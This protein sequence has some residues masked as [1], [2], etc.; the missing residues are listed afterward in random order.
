MVDRRVEQVAVVGDDDRGAR[1]ALQ[2]VVEPDRTLD[3]EV[4]GRL[5]EQQ[6]VGLGEQHRGE[7]HPHPPATGEVGAGAALRGGIEAEAVQDRRRP[8][9]GGV[10]ADI[11]EPRLDLGPAQT[12]GVPGLRDQ[13]RPLGVGG[14]H[15]GMQGLGA[16]GRLLRH[17][18][19]A[20]ALRQGDGFRI[21]RQISEDR[22]EQRGLAG[23]VAPDEADARTLGDR[24]ARGIEDQALAEAKGEVVHAQHGRVLAGPGR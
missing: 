11:D 14:E 9:G 4:V 22:L 19:D 1:I 24:A 7:R 3:V 6:Q 18:T 8:G 15:D 5:V 16:R 2:V 21:D 23:A 12:V 13:A 20:H 10:R 17:R